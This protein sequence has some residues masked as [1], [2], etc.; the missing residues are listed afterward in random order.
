M[1][2]AASLSFLAA[3]AFFPKAFH[4]R[5]KPTLLPT[6]VALLSENIEATVQLEVKQTACSYL[7][8]ITVVYARDFQKYLTTTVIVRFSGVLCSLEK[9]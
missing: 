2:L 1:Y 4:P 5:K 6:V 3:F 7:I 8:I 9:H